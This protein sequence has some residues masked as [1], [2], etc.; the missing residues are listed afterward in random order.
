MTKHGGDV[1]GKDPTLSEGISTPPLLIITVLVLPSGVGVAGTGTASSFG[2][3]GS[4]MRLQ[5]QDYRTKPDFA[6]A[7][8]LRPDYLSV[9]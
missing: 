1:S 6:A 7:F 3:W 4:A 9:R 5:R 2:R 8:Q